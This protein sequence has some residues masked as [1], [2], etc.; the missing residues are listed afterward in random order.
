MFGTTPLSFNTDP[1]EKDVAIQKMYLRLCQVEN[2]L[3]QVKIWILHGVIGLLIFLL[4]I[5]IAI[6]IKKW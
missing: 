3:I 4:I 2:N 6:N 1:D 5:S